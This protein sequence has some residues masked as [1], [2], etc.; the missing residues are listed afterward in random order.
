[1]LINLAEDILTL[2]E[3]RG[4]TLKYAKKLKETG[5]PIVLTVNGKPCVV[6]MDVEAFQRLIDRLP[7]PEATLPIDAAAEHS[8]N[9]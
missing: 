7:Q 1:M 6:A 9:P 3:F 2:T 4:K 5:R 8:H